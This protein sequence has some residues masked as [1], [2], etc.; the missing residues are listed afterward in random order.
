MSVI[1]LLNAARW[2]QNGRSYWQINDLERL[3]RMYKRVSK[4][5]LID[6]RTSFKATW[7]RILD[8]DSLSNPGR[9]SYGFALMAHSV[10]HCIGSAHH[11]IGI[12]QW[13]IHVP[14]AF[15]VMHG[16]YVDRCPN[17]KSSFP[18]HGPSGCN[19]LSFWEHLLLSSWGCIANPRVVLIWVLSGNFQSFSP[20]N[21]DL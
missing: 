20:F 6:D 21:I 19:I 10:S 5:S 17:L 12:D 14:C 1:V 18:C 13:Y 9:T 7:T 4:L 11:Q 3:L 15:I 2:T 8:C 16:Q